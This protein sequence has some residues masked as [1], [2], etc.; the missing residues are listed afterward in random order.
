MT[1]LIAMYCT[2][3]LINRD[4][5]FVHSSRPFCFNIPDCLF[6]L[7]L[8][9]PCYSS[10]IHQS[11]LVLLDHSHLLLAIAGPSTSQIKIQTFI[12]RESWLVTYESLHE[13]IILKHILDLWTHPHPKLRALQS[14]HVQVSFT[15]VERV[16]VISAHANCLYHG[17]NFEDEA[18][19]FGFT[20]PVR[21]FFWPDIFVSLNPTLKHHRQHQPTKDILSLIIRAHFTVNL[22]L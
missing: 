9:F 15:E 20:Q 17:P 14:L 10:T 4:S 11:R 1:T 21:I 18:H 5:F 13:S 22:V 3:M 12:R 6:S 2:S 7:V 8:P 16:G 19:S